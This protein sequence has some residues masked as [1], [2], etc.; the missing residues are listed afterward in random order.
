MLADFVADFSAK[1]MHEAEK[2]ATRASHV[3]QDLWVLHNY[4][5]SNACGY[6]LGLVLEIPNGEVVRQSIRCLDMTNNETE[7]EAVITGLRLAL[8]YGERHLRLR[9]DSQLVVNQVIGTFQIK[10]QRLQKYLS[11]I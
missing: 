9:C 2:E 8:E 3:T 1:V 10:E 11:Q 7:Y 4:G 5:A 6:R